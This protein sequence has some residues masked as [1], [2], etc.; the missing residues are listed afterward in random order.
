MANQTISGQQLHDMVCV[1]A[2]FLEKNKKGIDAL[3]VFPVPDGDTGIN[4]SLTMQSAAKEVKE[5]AKDT[6]HAVGQG[7]ALGSLKGARGN[8]GVILS[9]IFRGFG[10]AL[11]NHTEMDASLLA[12]CM[13]MGVEAAYKAVM[14]PKEGTILTVS[15]MM[16]K[17]GQA[18]AK[19]GLGVLATI[20]RMIEQGE[21]TLAQT[22]DLLPVLKEAGVVDSGGMGLLVIF[23]GFRMCLTGEQVPEEEITDLGGYV[24]P[25]STG[26]EEGGIEFGYCTEFFIKDPAG[27]LTEEQARQLRDALGKIG[28]C[29][30]VVGEGPLLKVHV[31]TNEPGKA[32]QYGLS[33]GSLSSIKI[34]NMR[35]QHRVLEG[36]ADDELH[37]EAA[38]VP[39]AAAVPKPQKE[40]GVVSVVSGA[41]LKEVF[42][43]LGVDQM[44]EGGQSMNPSIEDLSKAIVEANAK[45]VFVLPN[46]KN[47]LLAA[48]Q[49][50]ELSKEKADVI[51][52]PTLSIPQGMSALIALNPDNTV[53]ENA[54]SMLEAIQ[55]VNSAQVT[56]AVRDTQLNGKEIK[57]GD[58]LGMVNGDLITSGPSI[59]Q[60][61]QEVIRKARDNGGESIT[62]FYG[63]DVTPEAS[64]ALLAKLEEEYPDY[65]VQMY[66]GGQQLY[67][68]IVGVE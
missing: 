20:E 60:V 59:E 55:A 30:L 47:I 14:K 6:V 26:E 51:V 53:Q 40:Y 64:E 18:A 31:H 61:C 39:K 15:R 5:G 21:K 33:Y 25:T 63:E 54:S 19:E 13:E 29:V 23:R 3:N 56:Y 2:A 42:S 22:P 16:A 58:I 44:V 43:E 12:L 4:M 48:E 46:N 1:A 50:A 57:K 34:D 62:L 8:S 68:Y 24:T 36:G 41:G 10:K 37:G 52:I 49:A 7:L 38:T 27:N 35:E 67:Y 9:Q 65:D 11:E 32:L 66:P 17:E 45:H 28:D